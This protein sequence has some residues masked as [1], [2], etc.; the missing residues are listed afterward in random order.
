MSDRWYPWE[1]HPDGSMSVS[2]TKVVLSSE[3]IFR[4]TV[5]VTISRDIRERRHLIEP[6]TKKER[7]VSELDGILDRSGIS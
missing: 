3:D 5:A 1:L 4:E 6:R 2:D 7:Q